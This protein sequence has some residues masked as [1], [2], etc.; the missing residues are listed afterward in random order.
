MLLYW[1]TKAA[2][3]I[4]PFHSPIFTPCFIPISADQPISGLKVG[5]GKTFKA[6]T[7]V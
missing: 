3:S 2:T 6:P 1:F 7:E 5:L 4:I